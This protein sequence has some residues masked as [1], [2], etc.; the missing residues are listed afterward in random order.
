MKFTIYLIIFSLQVYAQSEFIGENFIDSEISEIEGKIQKNNSIKDANQKYI[1]DV[2]ARIMTAKKEIEKLDKFISERIKNKTQAIEELNQIKASVDLKNPFAGNREALFKCLETAI[3]SNEA[4][5]VYECR[6]KHPIGSNQ[7]EKDFFK[8][9]EEKLFL[10]QKDADKKIDSYK[11]DIEV[12]EKNKKQSKD[13]YE[14]SKREEDRFQK[15]LDLLMDIKKDYSVIKSNSNIANCDSSSPELNLENEVPFPGAD[16]KGFLHGVPRDNQDGVGS[17]YA[18]AGRILLLGATDGEADASFLDMALQ[19]KMSKKE[20]FEDGLDGG[21]TCGAI[22]A[23]KENGYC[24]KQEAP[25][26][27]GGNNPVVDSLLGESK[28]SMYLQSMTLKLLKEFI[29]SNELINMKG[30]ISDPAISKKAELI[31]QK[32]KENSSLKLPLPVARFQI[33]PR[34]KLSLSYYLK[35]NSIGISE[36]EFLREHE[37]R[38]KKFFPK[39]LGLLSQNKSREFI[40][41]EFIKDNKDFVEKYKMENEVPNWKEGFLID[42]A[43]DYNQK[44][45]L[46]SFNDSLVFLKELLNKSDLSNE[47]FFNSCQNDFSEEFQML[48]KLVPLV[49]KLKENKVDPT[50]LIDTEGRFKKGADLMQLAL[51]PNCL[52]PEN[53]KKIEKEFSCDDG[54]ST[55][56][57]IK[58][59]PYTPDEKVKIFRERILLSLLKGL[60]VGN[61]FVSNPPTGHINTIVGMRFNP[62]SSRCEYLIRESQD[63]T[64]V[65]KQ[66]SEIFNKINALVEVR[67]K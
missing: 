8:F 52:N 2:D 65:W 13:Y 26:E 4:V 61:S 51:A 12:Y 44:T 40:F 57:K 58:N 1:T 23:I 3:I 31:I 32:M 49:S 55:V 10:S 7:R 17:C 15:K 60:P 22:E 47:D 11:K 59:G 14:I 9:L 18:N 37:E 29:S 28:Y 27:N 20:L 34:R 35:K 5:P 39:Y 6:K 21:V 38:Y 33:P 19:Y 46:K 24:P 67:K 54:I 62:K 63:G 48:N 42:T 45:F 25:L 53:R 64:S 30:T 56:E 66:E 41:D 16:F 50:K 36:E 43:E